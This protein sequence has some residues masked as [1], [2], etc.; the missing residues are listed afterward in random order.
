MEDNDAMIRICTTGRNPTMRH[1]NRTHGISIRWLYEQFKG[2]ANELH[3]CPTDLQCADIFTKAFDNP[4]KWHH[5]HM[6]INVIPAFSLKT[7]DLSFS[8]QWHDYTRALDN[9]PTLRKGKEKALVDDGALSESGG[10]SLAR[11]S[12]VPGAPDG[13]RGGPTRNT[14]TGQEV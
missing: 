12:S 3:Y 13:P 1:I 5:A 2:K 4:E 8:R 9:D 7:P 14:E 10:V 6:L 11:S